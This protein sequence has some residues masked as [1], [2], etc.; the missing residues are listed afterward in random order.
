MVY[1]Q[2][3]PRI[4]RGLVGELRCSGLGDK[5]VHEIGLLCILG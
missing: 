3:R 5:V 1:P 4:N 2:S